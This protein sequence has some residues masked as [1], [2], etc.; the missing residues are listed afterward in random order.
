MTHLGYNIARLRGFKRLTQK[1]IAS[2]LKMR[3][4]D[5][6]KIENSEFVDDMLLDSIAQ[7]LEMPVELI[8]HLDS[9]SAISYNQKGGNTGSIFYQ[10]NNDERIIE[11]Y[12]RLLKEKDALIQQ[13]DA[14]IQ[15]KDE[16]IA[17]YKKQQKPSL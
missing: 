1:E 2:K 14:V 13:K 7:A 17:L 10:T 8:K 11:V 12:E 4:Q 16:V 9:N 6:S 3:Q 15:Q 5:Y